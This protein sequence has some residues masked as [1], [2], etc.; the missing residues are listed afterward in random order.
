MD[1]DKGESGLNADPIMSL[2][3]AIVSTEEKVAR[4]GLPPSTGNVDSRRVVEIHDGEVV[5][6][7][8]Q[9]EKILLAVPDMPIYKFGNVLVK[10]TWGGFDNKDRVLRTALLGVNGVLNI[11]NEFCAFRKWS[12]SFGVWVNCNCPRYIAEAYLERE[13]N[14]TIK[15]IKSA[16]TTPILR[17]NGSLV[18]EDGYDEE[19][20]IYINKF[21]KSF[22]M[23]EGKEEDAIEGLR[24]LNKLLRYF[25]FQ[26]AKDKSVALSGIITAVVRQ[27]MDTAPMHC[28]DAPMAG[29]G[30]SC[31]TN[32]ASVLATGQ[33]AMMVAATGSKGDE[34]EKRLV[35]AVLYGG[36][37]IALDNIGHVLDNE[38]LCQLITEDKVMVRRLGFSEL[39]EIPS[40]AT[41]FA[42]GNN[43][44]VSGD[45]IRRC[46]VG[47]LTASVERPELTKYPF[48]PVKMAMKRRGRLIWACLS[49]VMGHLKSGHQSGKILGSFEAWNHMVRDALIWLGEEDPVSVMEATRDY[50]PEIEK[51]RRL[52][53]C[54]LDM[55]GAEQRYFS[56][57]VIAKATEVEINDRGTEIKHVELFDIISEIGHGKPNPNSFGWYL[58]KVRDKILPIN[59]ACYRFEMITSIKMTKGVPWMLHQ[60]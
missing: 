13:K 28:F 32:I 27:A 50:D 2:A 53:L 54:W 21:G 36:R 34:F 51:L 5:A 37:F 57:E 43:L 25:T 40:V 41:Y 55:F 24:L 46:L 59:N 38:L 31:L 6:D 12:R 17:R 4:G 23:V 1:E 16:I 35:A 49:I 20:G 30:K 3:D 8:E 15:P 11:F 18:C 60:V 56:R 48:D 22:P 44:I 39:V 42:N 26:S 9:I 45:L 47:R 29:S 52:M 10:I 19:S 14:W 58:R 33:R 7:I